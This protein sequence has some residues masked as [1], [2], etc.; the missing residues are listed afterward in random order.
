MSKSY[1]VGLGIFFLLLILLTSLEANE[2]EPINWSPSYTAADKIPLG[3]YVLFDQ[4]R[5]QDLEMEPIKIPPY[6]FLINNNPSGTYFFLNNQLSFDDD[7]L[8]K[9]LEWVEK[10]NTLFL[11]AEFFSEN[12]L[13]TLK[14]ELATAVPDGI[15]SKPMLNLVNPELESE[16]AF[17]FDKEGYYS[18]FSEID[19]LAHTILGISELFSD[20]LKIEDPEVNYLKTAFGQGEIYLHST[21][22]AFGNFFMLWK[23]NSEYV[24]KTLAYLPT[25]EVLYWDQ[26]YK[27]GKSFYTSPLYILLNNKALKWAYY[28]AILGAVLF[29]IFEGKRKQ[30]SIPVVKPLENKTY[31]FTRT[32]AGLYLDQKDFRKIASKK[33][34]LFL[35]YIREN[36]R[37]STNSLDEEFYLKLSAVSGNSIEEVQE[38]FEII[39]RLQHRKSVNKDELL[40]LNSA[41]DKFKKKE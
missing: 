41:I 17:L 3:T 22:Q 19:T 29:V 1:K 33:I 21:P 13:D 5:G 28:F 9:I 18:Y 8:H 10:G 39:Q 30:R 24:E 2:P 6:E 32:I 11:S 31:D 40:K 27:A 12:L 14:L 36:F 35:D 15:S 25:K 37:I 16:E 23:N 34:D 7:E 20:S 26:Y 38:L 4:L